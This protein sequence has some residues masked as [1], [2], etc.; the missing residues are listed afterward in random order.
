MN[1]LEAYEELKKGN[2]V[3]FS[4]FVTKGYLYMPYIKADDQTIYYCEN[5]SLQHQHL[6]MNWDRVI[7]EWNLYDGRVFRLFKAGR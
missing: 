1:I 7:G 4:R 5:D 3:R 2:K 6:S